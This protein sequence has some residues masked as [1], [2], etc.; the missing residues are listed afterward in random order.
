MKYFIYY[1]D[2]LILSKGHLHKAVS[3]FGTFIC[4]TF[5]EYFEFDPLIKQSSILAA[6][7]RRKLNFIP[8]IIELFTFF[9]HQ[10]I[11][12]IFIL[13]RLSQ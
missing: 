11:I 12:Y 10:H 1:P 6:S 2:A 5:S 8:A 3:C 13:D 7:Q 4:E 9:W